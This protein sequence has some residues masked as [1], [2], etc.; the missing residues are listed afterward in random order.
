M[1]DKYATLA[2]IRA[3]SNADLHAWCVW[4]DNGNGDWEG[5][6][7]ETAILRANVAFAMDLYETLEAALEG[8]GY[9]S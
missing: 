7:D 1:H 2:A 3:A 9:W 6:E 5:M 4:N 8:E